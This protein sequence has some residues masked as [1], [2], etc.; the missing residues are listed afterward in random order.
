[1]EEVTLVHN[2][3]EFRVPSCL[4][5]DVSQEILSTESCQ[6]L[7]YQRD[8]FSHVMSRDTWSSVLS[9]NDRHELCKLLPQETTASERDNILQ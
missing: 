8:V 1:M 7:F 6:I 5:E 2:G 9:D 4:L 3:E